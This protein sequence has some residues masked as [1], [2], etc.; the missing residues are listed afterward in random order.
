MDGNGEDLREQDDNDDVG[1]GEEWVLDVYLISYF[2]RSYSS[3]I[4]K[5]KNKQ[6]NQIHQIK[7]KVNE[8]LIAESFELFFNRV[9]MDTTNH[10]R[11]K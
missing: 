2:S 3:P 10:V 5:V 8:N 4:R 11:I 1:K 6:I 9:L 7:R